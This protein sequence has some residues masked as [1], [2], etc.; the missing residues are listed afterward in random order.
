MGATKKETLNDEIVTVEKS[1]LS[2]LWKKEDWLAVWIGTILIVIAAVSVR[3]IGLPC[4]KS[5]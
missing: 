1:K 4:I 2:D 3:E 5:K